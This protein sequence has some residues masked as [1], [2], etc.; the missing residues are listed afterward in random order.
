VR[1]RKDTVTLRK[2]E[3]RGHIQRKLGGPMRPLQCSCLR[4]LYLKLAI[5]HPAKKVMFESL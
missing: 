2:N 5:Y 1:A 3:G 4:Q